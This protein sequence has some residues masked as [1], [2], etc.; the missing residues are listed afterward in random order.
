[1]G[2]SD[3]VDEHIEERDSKQVTAL[4]HGVQ[5]WRRAQLPATGVLLP[6]QAQIAMPL[7][8]RHDHGYDLI[9]KDF[10]GAGHAM[11]QL[12]TRNR[13]DQIAAISLTKTRMARDLPF[14]RW[15]QQRPLASKALIL[16]FSTIIEPLL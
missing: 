8:R 7:K 10:E 6:R 16:P 12:T 1:M 15:P 11:G 14:G 2:S 9:A 5:R 4:E 13:S 3:G